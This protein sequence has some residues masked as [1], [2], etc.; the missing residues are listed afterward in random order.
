MRA[1]VALDS[2]KIEVQGVPAGVG[3]LDDDLD[4]LGGFEDGTVG[5]GQCVCVCAAEGLVGRD[6]RPCG[7]IGLLTL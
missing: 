4:F 1:G 2:G 7:S 3:V 5:H 6:K